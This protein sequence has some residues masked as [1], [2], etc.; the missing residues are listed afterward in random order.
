MKAVKIFALA[1]FLVTVLSGCYLPV[2]FDAEIEIDRTGYYSIIFDG[3]MAEHKLFGDLKQKK[4]TRQ[5]E[6]E[7]VKTLETDFKRDK[8]TKEFKYFKEGIFKVHW[9]QKG[10]LLKHGMVTFVRRNEKILTVY[11]SKKR[12]RI[13]VEGKSLR[14]SNAEQLTKLGLGMQGELRIKTNANVDKHNAHRVIKKTGRDR[15]Y[16]WKVKSLFDKSPKLSI[17]FR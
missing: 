17:L 7:K 13:F 3:Y 2:R 4:I 1:A 6:L 12:Q 14:K 10:D 9:T 8:S 16:V 15:I 5:Q 11:Y